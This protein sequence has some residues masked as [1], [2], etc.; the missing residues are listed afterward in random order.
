MKLRSF[1]PA[2]IEDVIAASPIKR[3]RTELGGSHTVVTYPPLGALERIDEGHDLETR[4][5]TGKSL[6][7]YFHIAYCEHI[8][9]FCHYAK[10]FSPI[11]AE[12]SAVTSYMEALAGEIEMR[13]RVL[14]SSNISSI[15]V[16]GGTPTSIS[17]D[18]LDRLFDVIE[19]NVSAMPKNICVETSPQTAE[20]LEGVEKLRRLKTRG[21]NRVSIGIQTSD[22][23]LLLRSR[24]HGAGTMRRALDNVAALGIEFNVD[25]IQDLPDQTQD[26]IFKD[27]DVVKK[28]QPDQVTWYIMRPDTEAAW[29][30]KVKNGDL[31][32]GPDEL[33]S[34]R[35]RFLINR[36]MRSLGYR[37]DAGGRFVKAHE[38]YDIY[39]SV[40]NDTQSFL[41]GFG[42]SAYSH[43][44][45]G[46]ARS[47]NDHK[48]KSGIAEY[49]R[50]IN[51]GVSAID[52]FF[53]MDS[54]ENRCS[55]RIVALRRE[56]TAAMLAGDDLDSVT[57][58]ALVHR[59]V[60]W[61]LM[62]SKR[63][64]TFRLT[65]AGLVYEEEITSLFYS[66]KVKR[67]LRQRD[68]YWLTEDLESYLLGE[69]AKLAS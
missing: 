54:N 50:R 44:P 43:S 53:A 38:G 19:Q 37:Q 13:R 17:E 34:A 6:N 26:L 5:C 42:V 29:Y 36:E 21:M 52:A 51:S 20:T 56:L 7:L 24:G 57:A 49:I 8:C 48:I 15:Y 46:F 58:R 2:E 47:V 18:A 9:P 60:G 62:T 3:V 64:Q 25:F 68:A 32:A 55:Q 22:N 59:L 10:T 39:K 66:Q 69:Q 14:M 16:G 12:S 40:R 30:K 28:Y 61:G 23:R 67:K 11:D 4:L 45:K 63:G 65:E 33:E 31:T 41:L 27:L 35:R 1:I